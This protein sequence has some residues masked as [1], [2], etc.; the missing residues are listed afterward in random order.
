MTIRLTFALASLLLFAQQATALTIKEALEL[1]Q[2]TGRP[3]LAMAG[4]K[5]CGA[6]KALEQRLATDAAVQPLIAQ[7]VPLKIDTETPDWQ[8]WASR[9]QS[10][11]DSIPIVYVVRADGE[12]LFGESATLGGSALGQFLTQMLKQSS[13]SLSQQQVAEAEEALATA[14]ASLQSENVAEAIQT[15]APYAS[16]GSYAQVA[17]SIDK[18]VE[19]LT[20]QGETQWQDALSKLEASDESDALEGAIALVATQRIFGSLPELKV[21]FNTSLRDVRRKPE[22]R[23]L[24]RHAALIDKAQV[25]EDEERPERSVSIYR[26]L[27]G[28]YAGQS[29]GKLAQER[30]AALEKQGLD[31]GDPIAAGA[32]SDAD[33]DSET[34]SESTPDEVTP[35]GTDSKDLRRAESYLRLAQTFAKNSPEKAIEYAQKAIDAAAGTQVAMD[36]QQLI[37]GLK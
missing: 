2:Q 21:T 33:S 16:S 22:S 35:A 10:T 7:F 15:V 20:R 31:V 23:D 13:T 11:G 27:A 4:S 26:T 5:S 34:P 30:L 19:S 25:Y 24:M 18:M 14:T 29:A 6:C 12:Q 36:A 8:S 9:F 32:D 37:D 17:V 3:I 1:S 28:K